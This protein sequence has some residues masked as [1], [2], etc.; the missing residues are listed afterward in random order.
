MRV[1]GDNVK[2]VLPI[3]CLK[4]TILFFSKITDE[5]FL[6]LF[7]NKKCLITD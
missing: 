4:A 3:L 7:D 6:V 1:S 5:N 2:N